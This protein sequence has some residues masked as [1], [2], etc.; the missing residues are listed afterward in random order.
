[1]SFLLRFL[2]SSSYANG[3]VVVTRTSRRL[4]TALTSLRVRL[5][6]MKRPRRLLGVMMK[7]PRP[8]VRLGTALRKLGPRQTCLV[9]TMKRPRPPARPETAL[10]KLAPRRPCLVAT[11]HPRRLP[12]ATMKQPR[13]PARPE[14]ASRKL[15][16][17][18]TRSVLVVLLSRGDWIIYWSWAG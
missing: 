5:M 2:L 6:A 11:R 13:P 9:V 15:A 10:R 7:R 8:P 18:R 17:R 12:V 16:L 3:A 4:P 1:M 14:T